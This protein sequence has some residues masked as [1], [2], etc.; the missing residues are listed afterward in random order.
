MTSLAVFTHLL[1]ILGAYAACHRSL[2]AYIVIL[3][4]KNYA[5]ANP[6]ATPLPTDDE[7]DKKP[8]DQD[9]VENA[10][11]G[12]DTLNPTIKR[13]SLWRKMLD[14]KLFPVI[15]L[16]SLTAGFTVFLVY[17]LPKFTSTSIRN[18]VWLLMA[19]YS[20]HGSIFSTMKTLL[21]RPRIDKLTI[22]KSSIEKSK[23]TYSSKQIYL[24]EEEKNSA[25]SPETQLPLPEIPYYTTPKF[26]RL[27]SILTT[28]AILS[29]GYFGN[30][31]L[32]FIIAL[33]QVVSSAGTLFLVKLTIRFVLILLIGLIS[34]A[35]VLIPLLNHL[36]PNK[37][38]GKT[39]QKEPIGPVWVMDAFMMYN[40]GM[41]MML[42]AALLAITHRFEYLNSSSYL[43]NPPIAP[44]GEIQAPLPRRDVPRFNRPITSAGFVALIASVI[45]FHATA[46]YTFGQK[47]YNQMI[48]IIGI[49]FYALPVT[50]LGMFITA[51]INGNS[52]EWLAYQ[53]K[54]WPNVTAENLEKMRALKEQIGEKE[55]MMK[56]DEDLISWNDEKPDSEKQHA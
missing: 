4:M 55:E 2:K 30:L 56:I 49:M 35:A 11:D 14:S 54:W 10:S 52:R 6:T 24:S 23:Y 20:I 38:A 9:T 16:L 46:P 48:S 1:C 32:C 40:V 22:I 42:P 3:S 7:D 43:S 13:K 33:S 31:W 44:N 15:I 34:I 12:K 39:E 17:G 36:F 50:A 45:T 26:Q 37:N 41:G 18:A 51:V 19:S 27:I 5:E 29:T 53:D 28:I 47:E 8:K 21:P 25:S